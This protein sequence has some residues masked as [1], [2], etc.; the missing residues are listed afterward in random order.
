MQ[1]RV[2]LNSRLLPLPPNF[3]DC[4]HVPPCL[5]LCGAGDGTWG[6]LHAG[7]ALSPLSCTV[8]PAHQVFL[9]PFV[10]FFFFPKIYLFS[11]KFFVSGSSA[12]I[13]LPTYYFMCYTHILEGQTH[14]SYPVL[15]FKIMKDV[16]IV[17]F[18]IIED[19]VP[20]I[21]PKFFPL[22]IFLF[23]L[24]QSLFIKNYE[25]NAFSVPTQTSSK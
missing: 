5:A 15:F 2:T 8:S 9:G 12:I 21:S 20:C 1:A 3:Q 19:Q 17:F 7:Q 18:S 25:S 10:L 22:L 4:R 16:I 13:I 24:K 6:F 14:L 23:F 11:T